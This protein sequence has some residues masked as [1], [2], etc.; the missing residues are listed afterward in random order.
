MLATPMTFSARRSTRVSPFSLKHTTLAPFL[1]SPS[2]FELDQAAETSSPEPFLPLSSNP[3]D[4]RSTATHCPIPRTVTPY[5]PPRSFPILPRASPSLCRARRHL[6]RA[7]PLLAHVD[8]P[9]PT[10]SSMRHTTVRLP[11]FLLCSC[12]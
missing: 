11:T 9:S 5:A 7:S 4:S 2:P 10:I 1:P 8:R 3:S 12:L 6:H